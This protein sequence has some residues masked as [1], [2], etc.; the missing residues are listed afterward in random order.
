MPHEESERPNPRIARDEAQL[1]LGQIHGIVWFAVFNADKWLKP[2]PTTQ[3]GDSDF[4]D[5]ELTA[6]DI[7]RAA[8]AMHGDFGKVQAALNTGK[9]DEE[10]W[11][12][13]LAGPQGYAKKR[14]VAA[15]LRHL[16][17]AEKPIQDYLVRLKGALRWSRTIIGSITAALKKEIEHVPGAAAAA[18]AI[19]EFLE[20]LQNTAESSGGGTRPETRTD[21]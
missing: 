2:P 18:E 8:I 14:G 11:N 10:L 15:A 6:E 21:R 12:V 1:M 19:G 7:R 17:R 9:H 3:D 16:F 13:A 20:I 5:P 4:A